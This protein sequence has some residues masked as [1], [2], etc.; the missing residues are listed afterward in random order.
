MRDRIT[1]VIGYRE[2]AA[3]ERQRAHLQQLLPSLP[4]QGLRLDPGFSGAALNALLEALATEYL[5]LLHAEPMVTVPERSLIRLLQVAE[6]SGA[7]IVYA[8]YFEAGGGELLARS[9]NDYQMG[10]VGDDFDFGPVLLISQ[11]VLRRALRHCGAISADLQWAGLYDLR[12]KIATVG[13]VMRVPECLFIR[14]GRDASS[15]EEMP[16]EEVFRYV[17]PRNRPAQQEMERVFIEH[18]RRLGAYLEPTF[19]PL[20]P[21]EGEYPVLASVVIPVRDRERTIADAV[22]SALSQRTSFPYNVI[23][24]DNHSTDRTTEILRRWA[25]TS[26]QLIHK[27]PERR[28]LG[29]GG[30]WN[31]AIFAPECGM[32]AVQLDSD[33]L[34]ANEGV[35]ETIVQA[36]F[37]PEV[38]ARAE[39]ARPSREWPR[40]RYAM[41]IG[42]YR[43]VNFRLE[44][45]PPGVV[46]H[47]EWTCENGRNNALRVK[48]C[49]A[50]R[51]YYVPL[52]RR[53][54]FPNVSYGEDYAMCLR[55]SREYEIGRLWDPIYMARRWE[56]NT[57]RALPWEVKMRYEAYK[58]WVRTLEIRARQRRNRRREGGDDPD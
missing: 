6:E 37:D 14:H 10:S 19:A 34:Y 57:D 53:F 33:D 45:I 47:R 17:D 9:M 44:E 51:A 52:L 15:S 11:R 27:I 28:D 32:L 12:L 25:S 29:I 30:C 5:V 21:P 8:D 50:P 3:F 38:F 46:D 13:D 16:V 26:P 24:V 41:V 39:W 48:G 56:G 55:L 20:P 35:L 43:T 58:D 49:G 42:A 1:L 22:R 7:G 2:A 4:I 54:G 40:P 31:E 36:F 23:V 18:L